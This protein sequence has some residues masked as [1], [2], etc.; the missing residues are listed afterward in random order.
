MIHAVAGN[1]T[2][3]VAGNSDVGDFAF[4]LSSLDQATPINVGT[5]FDGELTVPNETDFYQF[6]ALQGDELF[7]DVTAASDTG[8]AVY[9]LFDPFGTLVFE[10]RGLS[11][12]GRQVIPRDGTYTL[13]FE[14]R[15]SNTGTDTYSF[16][17]EPVV[18]R[19]PPAALR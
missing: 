12:F 11:D 19:T 8:N 2:L 14:G 16:N 5:P 3:R 10:R 18:H 9:R 1:Y 4:R 15:R 17:I 7:F 13:L 6:S